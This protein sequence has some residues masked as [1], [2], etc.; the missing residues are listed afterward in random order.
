MLWI[1]GAVWSYKAFSPEVNAE[2]ILR[3]VHSASS[4]VFKC[5][6]WSSVTEQND[7]SLDIDLSEFCITAGL[8]W[9]TKTGVLDSE[10]T[11]REWKGKNLVYC[12]V[13][14]LYFRGLFYFPHYQYLLSWG[15]DTAVWEGFTVDQK[16]IYTPLFYIPSPYLRTEVAVQSVINRCVP[17]PISGKGFCNCVP[18]S[19]FNLLLLPSPQQTTRRSLNNIFTGTALISLVVVCKELAH[20]IAKEFEECKFI[21]SRSIPTLLVCSVIRVLSF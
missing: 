4:E 18:A 12:M 9:S 2:V 1:L 5:R 3:I 13:N 7:S 19:L 20:W 6:G 21:S 14:S 17:S 15:I 10:D 16:Q 11:K 8:S